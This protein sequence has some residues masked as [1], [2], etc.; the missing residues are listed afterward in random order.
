[1]LSKELLAISGWVWEE[2][3]KLGSGW[4]SCWKACEYRSLVRG[5]LSVFGNGSD[6]ARKQ[7]I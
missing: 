2:T 7:T 5:S 6:Y 1:M 4:G 3:Q